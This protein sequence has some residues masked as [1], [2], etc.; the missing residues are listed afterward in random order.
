M[1]DPE[2]VGDLFSGIIPPKAYERSRKAIETSVKDWELHP[3][4]WQPFCANVS[5]T[6]QDSEDGIIELLTAKELY[7]RCQ[8]CGSVLKWD[9]DQNCKMPLKPAFRRKE[10][11]GPLDLAWYQCAKYRD[12]AVSRERMR[13]EGI[14]VAR[15]KRAQR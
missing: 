6:K 2:K 4:K 13:K 11:E 9:E 12:W 10:P 1:G 7:E 15:Q 14:S 3:S 5:V 8:R